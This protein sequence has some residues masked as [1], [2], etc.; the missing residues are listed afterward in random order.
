MKILVVSHLYPTPHDSAYGIFVHQQSKALAERGHEVKIVSPTPYV[1]KWLGISGRWKKFSKVPDESEIS[2][3]KVKYPKYISVPSRI[4]LPLVAK[5]VRRTVDHQIRDMVSTDE[6]NPDVVHSHVPLPDGYACFPICE[7]LNI[8]LVTSVHGASIY[9]SSNNRICRRQIS[10]VFNNS[11]EIIFNSAT[12]KDEASLNYS[13]L[14][15]S[16]VVHN[17][18][19]VSKIQSAPTADLDDVFPEDRLVICS[20][21]SLTERKSHSDVIKALSEF[22]ADDRPYYLIIGQGPIQDRLQKQVNE[23]DLDKYVHFTGHVSEHRDVFSKLK[24]ADVM[25]L[26][27][28]NEAFGIAY[29]EAMACTCPVIG[30]TGEGLSG[31][32]EDGETG[33]FVQHNS[34]Y[35]LAEKIQI[36]IDDLENLRRMSENARNFSHENFSWKT[37]SREVEDILEKAITED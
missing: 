20:L 29:I 28:K 35:K 4:T 22:D 27:S 24:A 30:C 13:G 26:P 37:N 15:R 9:K 18:I 3:I 21:G 2:G 36:F 8:P 12:L 5:S 1:P 6:F 23:Q 16:H 14:S 11:S 34:P 19:P 7:E 32:V 17:G 33:Y 25:V 10:K 31:F